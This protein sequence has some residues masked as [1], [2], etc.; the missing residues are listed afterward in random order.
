MNGFTRLV[1]PRHMKFDVLP[2]P[3]HFLR[4]KVNVLSV[5]ELNKMVFL[6]FSFFFFVSLSCVGVLCFS[7]TVS[8]LY[9]L[10]DRI[11]L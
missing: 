10:V 7:D 6:R 11:Q 8:R 9:P 1:R 2:G 5:I 3:N 4:K